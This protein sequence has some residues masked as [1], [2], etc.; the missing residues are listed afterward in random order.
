MRLFSQRCCVKAFGHSHQQARRAALKGSDPH[1]MTANLCFEQ[2]L[3]EEKRSGCH[4]LPLRR[5]RGAQGRLFAEKTKCKDEDRN[6]RLK[7]FLPL[8]SERQAVPLPPSSTKPKQGSHPELKDTLEA[9]CSGA[10][11]SEVA[12]ITDLS[13]SGGHSAHL[14]PGNLS[15]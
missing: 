2:G 4:L 12:F 1:G 15:Q 8:P 11:A 5:V 9:I 14:L 3:Q 13:L 7:C 10:H 6:T